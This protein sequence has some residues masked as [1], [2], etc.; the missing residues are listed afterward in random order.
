MISYCYNESDSRYKYYGAN[1]VRVCDSWRSD[2]C[3]FLEDLGNPPSPH[4]RLERIDKRGDFEPDNCH[5]QRR[6]P[7]LRKV[8]YTEEWPPIVIKSNY[9]E[10]SYDE[11]D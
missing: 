5:W 1:S 2:F 11:N 4:H 6:T 9:Y 8:G 7:K 3:A 10:F